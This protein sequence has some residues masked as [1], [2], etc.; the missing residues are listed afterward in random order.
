[1]IGIVASATIRIGRKALANGLM[2]GEI[3]VGAF[4]AIFLLHVPFPVIVLGPRRSG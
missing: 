3:A 2:V 1:M 4:V